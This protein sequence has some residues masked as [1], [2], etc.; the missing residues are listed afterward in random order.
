MTYFVV[1]RD[2]ASTGETKIF[3]V[4]ASGNGQWGGLGNGTYSNCQGEPVKVKDISGI[5]E[6]TLLYFT[7]QG[8][9]AWY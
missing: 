9:F 7:S 3:D 5:M 1:E 2:V 4:L 8:D 6:C